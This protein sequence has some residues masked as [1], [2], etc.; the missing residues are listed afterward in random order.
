MADQESA[1]TQTLP[2]FWSPSGSG[3]RYE[4][5]SDAHLL[6]DPPTLS[7]GPDMDSTDYLGL[8][9]GLRFHNP[10][11]H[12]NH[13][14]DWGGDEFFIG[15]RSISS[16]SDSGSASINDF[17]RARPV[18]DDGLQVLDFES[19]SD[20]DEQIVAIGEYPIISNHQIE[21]EEMSN[22]SPNHNFNLPRCWDCLRIDEGRRDINEEFEW[23]EIDGRLEER[24]MINISNQEFDDDDDDDEDDGRVSNVEWE[25]LW[26]NHLGG[27]NFD[28]AES[29]IDEGF[30]YTTSDHDEVMLAQFQEH[31]DSSLKW[32][33][34]AAI[35]AVESLPSVVISKEDVESNSVSCAVCKDEIAVEERAKRLP[36]LHFYHEEC[37][38]PWLNMR[39][40]CPLCRHELP[41]DNPEYERWKAR[42]AGNA[43]GLE[44]VEDE[45]IRY[46]FEILPEA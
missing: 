18:G 19:D 10:H 35:S 38:L 1:D 39:N 30:V 5:D 43:G 3:S 6:Q 45:R 25:V 29:Y 32:S 34:P 7:L 2:V 11:H 14:G 28:D 12:H 13:G 36:C 15:R 24:E 22:P 31:H 23:E 4:P 27:G 44:V 42:R 8:D 37:I 41:T 20:S 40:T 9:L 26:T 46:D 16:E 17:S 33:L 21:E